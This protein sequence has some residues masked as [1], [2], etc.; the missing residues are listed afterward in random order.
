MCRD[1]CPLQLRVR[2][3]VLNLHNSNLPCFQAKKASCKR[4]YIPAEGVNA[5]LLAAASVKGCCLRQPALPGDS[6]RDSPHLS[7]PPGKRGEGTSTAL[8]VLLIPSEWLL[9]SWRSED[10]QNEAKS[11]RTLARTHAKL[12][13]CPADSPR[14][15]WD[16]RWRCFTPGTPRARMGSSRCASDS[17]F[18]HH[19]SLPLN[20][21]TRAPLHPVLL[22][23]APPRAGS[24]P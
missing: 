1:K 17:L 24:G 15:R 13:T 5:A 8:S 21:P 4:L 23:N 3:H 6:R 9:R 7:P 11:L 12:P 14:S 16:P 22:S 10:H 18:P 2:K 19:S 20:T